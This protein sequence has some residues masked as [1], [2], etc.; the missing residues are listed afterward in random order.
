MYGREMGFNL[1]VEFTECV[2]VNE[3]RIQSLHELN[4]MLVQY[5]TDY[6]QEQMNK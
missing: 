2:T 1:A 4:R 3:L 5:H 6:V